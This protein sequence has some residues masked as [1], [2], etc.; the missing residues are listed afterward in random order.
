[1]G[2]KV[3]FITLPLGKIDYSIIKYNPFSENWIIS[4]YIIVLGIIKC[5]KVLSGIFTLFKFVWDINKSI[6]NPN[7]VRVETAL[8][9]IENK[10][11]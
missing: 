5:N 11:E 4:I 7:V 6:F 1:M 9:Y 2:N 8:V 3:N 10:L